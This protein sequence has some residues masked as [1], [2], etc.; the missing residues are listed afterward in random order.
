MTATGSGSVDFVLLDIE[1]ILTGVG[2]AIQSPEGPL[3]VHPWR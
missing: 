3:K 2:R 1:L